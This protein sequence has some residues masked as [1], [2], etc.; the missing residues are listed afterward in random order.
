LCGIGVAE[1]ERPASILQQWRH[2]V[3]TGGKASGTQAFQGG[4]GVLRKAGVI[5]HL[6]RVHAQLAEDGGLPLRNP[7]GSSTNFNELT[8]IFAI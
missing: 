8:T 4:T 6:L 2:D 7:H 3:K 5:E 1:W